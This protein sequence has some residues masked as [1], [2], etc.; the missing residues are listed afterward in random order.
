MADRKDLIKTILDIINDSEVKE[1]SITDETVLIGEDGLF[2]DSIDVLELVV[3]IEKK[4]GVK[5]KDN[6][7]IQEKFK[8]FKTFFDFINENEKK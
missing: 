8:D 3:Q 7:L 1:D 5:V 2:F 4:Y 6:D